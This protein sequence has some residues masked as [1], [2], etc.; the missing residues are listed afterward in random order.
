MATTAK[1]LIENIKKWFP[2]ENELVHCLGIVSKAEFLESAYENH[3]DL[4]ENWVMPDDVFIA[5]S[6]SIDG[7]ENSLQHLWE[8]ITEIGNE[9]IQDYIDETSKEQELWE[10]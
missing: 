8:D 9:A 7:C 4:P 2:N 5:I 10:A 1:E 3:E 6:N